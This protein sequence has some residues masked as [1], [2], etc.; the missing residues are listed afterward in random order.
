M[1]LR[2][3]LKDIPLSRRKLLAG[4]AAGGGLLVAWTLWPRSYASPLVAREG[5]EAFGGWLTIARDGVV[6]LAVP[7]LEMGQ[8]IGTVLAQIAAV[9]LGADWR[10][11]GI[12]PVPPAGFFANLPLAAEWSPL[13][14]GWFGGGDDAGD[15]A[16]GKFARSNDFTVTACGTSLAAYEQPLREASASARDMLVRAAADRWDVEPEECEVAEGFVLH[17]RQRLPFGELVEEAAQF[18]PPDPAPLRPMPAFEE[19]L[20]GEGSAPTLFPRLD[21]PSK[22]DGS[23]L[24]AADVRLPG[25]VFASIRHGPVG[26]PELLRFSERAVANTRGLVGVVKSKRWIAAV[27]E[28]WWIAD[29]ALAKMRP[30]FTGPGTLEQIYLETEMERAIEREADDAE[31]IATVGEPD[32]MLGTP[33]LVRRF[34]VAPALHAPLE[35]A[36][37][38]ARLAE[39]RLELWMASQAPSAAR[40]AAA[41][42]IGISPSDV[43]IYPMSAG[44]SFDARLEKQHAIEVAQIAAEVG[45]PVQLTW[46][47]PQDM[48]AVPA[49]APVHADIAATLGGQG[50]PV[51]WRARITTPPWMR[52]AG[53][54]LFDNYTPEAAQRESRGEAD[55]FAVEGALPP[56]GISHVAIEHN[57]A[58]VTLPVG[59]MRGGAAPYTTFFTETVIDELARMAGRDPFLYRM[60]MLGGAP[61]MAE[62]LRRATRLGDWDGARA[63]SGEGIAAVRMGRDPAVAGHIACVAHVRR[64]EGGIKVEQLSAVVDIGRILNLDIARQQIEGGLLFGMGLALGQTLT[65]E[66]GHPVPRTLGDMNLPQLADTPDM[67][68]DFVQSDAEPFD[69]GELGVAVAPAAI[70]N[71]LFALTGERSYRLPLSP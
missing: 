9:E 60:A 54:R 63:G 17:D 47:R 26:L 14:E 64:G 23:H 18:D 43:V 44:G 3:K 5:E 57:P 16:V 51:A 69:P 66:S 4:A 61:R 7:Q 52:E 8:G 67:L 24:F 2:E 37:A 28:S 36:C 71:A 48:Q 31:R 68:I 34:D 40:D 21:L 35:T 1:D 12:E 53:H 55:P 29:N 41:K 58:K 70:A 30:E 45:R 22:V 6:T 32:A 39:G 10:Q 38:T 20:A 56:Y 13:W 33:T 49:R 11:V 65:F 27:A 50:Q 25:M 59:R 42:A 19:P 15:S 46:S 62:V